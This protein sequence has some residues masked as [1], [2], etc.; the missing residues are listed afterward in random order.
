[1]PLKINQH[2]IVCCFKLQPNLNLA[3]LQNQAYQNNYSV[4]I[5]HNFYT[6]KKEKLN[7]TLF[8]KSGHVNCSGLKNEQF[9]IT[10][11]TEAKKIFNYFPVKSE[12]TITNSTWSGTLTNKR[13]NIVH[14]RNNFP[15][16]R[17]RISLRSGIFPGAV[18]RQTNK[19]S[20]IIF[21]NGKFI[22][23]GARSQEHAFSSLQLLE[24]CIN[25]L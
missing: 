8:P 21:S 16:N 15:H 1:M 9:L 18:I 7:F 14:L 19:P 6:F 12:I 22:I 10:A 13:L 4:K 3:C 2:N 5:F 24:D 11:Q 17:G 25:S 23:V 20:I